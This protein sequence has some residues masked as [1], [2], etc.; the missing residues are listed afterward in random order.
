MSCH[1]ERVTSGSKSRSDTAWTRKTDIN[2]IYLE[3]EE[4]KKI[5]AIKLP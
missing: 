3:R 2:G 4:E 1:T 5:I